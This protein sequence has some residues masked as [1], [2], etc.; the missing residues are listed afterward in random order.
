[1]TN[2][3]FLKFNEKDL[4]EQPELFGIK[5]LSLETMK[6]QKRSGRDNLF[7]LKTGTLDTKIISKVFSVDDPQTYTK[8]EK[9]IKEMLTERK[10]KKQA[11]IR[12]LDENEQLEE[13]KK[14]AMAVTPK[15]KMKLRENH[16]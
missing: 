6:G 13:E 9:K 14:Q 16:F 1:M 4:L 2:I 7:E 3:G 5:T 11:M 15:G 8:W 12:P 10:T